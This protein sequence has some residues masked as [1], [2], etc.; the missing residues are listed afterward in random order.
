MK[1]TTTLLAI[2]VIVALPLATNAQRRSRSSSTRVS[3][4]GS[5]TSCSDIRVAF[6]RRPVITEETQMTL[7]A[8]QVSVFRAQAPDGGIYV[9]GWDRSDYSIKT[10][11]AVPDDD[12]NAAGTLRG[13]TTTVAGGR[14]S[15]TGPTVGEWMA[16]LIIMAPRTSSLDLESG[17]G[18]LHLRDLAGSIQVKAS[19]G[20]VSLD[21]IGGS[22]RAATVN[23]PMNIA[24]SGSG[25]EGPGLEA[26]SQNGPISVGIP[27]NYGSGIRIQTSGP[28][29]C[30]SSLCDQATRSLASPSI[31]QIGNGDPVVRLSTVNGP[32][33]IQRAQH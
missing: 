22:V 18:A 2:M 24:L 15:V 12:V 27:E 8:S 13:I 31:I 3:S 4:D 14:L 23:G 6:D 11:K 25:W 29:S 10:C 7:T 16:H 28:V 21:N 30:R 32:F 20:P 19:N 5:P 9:T 17:N 1:T 26:S 33:S